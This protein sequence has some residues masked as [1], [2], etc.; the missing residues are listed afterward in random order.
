[1]LNFLRCSCALFVLLGTGSVHSF[2]SRGHAIICQIAYD[3][4]TPKTQAKVDALV[5]LSP[6]QTFSTGCSWPDKV[7]DQTAFKH[8]KP[9][10]Y[11][12]VD[13]SA[14]S[15]NA[16]DCP[17]DGCVVSAIA[18]ME[19]RLV[20]APATDWQA[21]FFLG[22][23]IGDIH[24]PLHVSYGDDWGGNKV[25]VHLDNEKTNLHAVWDG[26]MFNSKEAYIRQQ[27]R[28][29]NKLT[30]EDVAL[31][32]NLDALVWANESY[33]VTQAIYQHLDAPI[34]LNRDELTDERDL[35]ELRIGL[36]ALRLAHVLET[37][38]GSS[39]SNP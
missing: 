29:M 37:L 25:K 39:T 26:R 13:R 34:A 5:S 16:D 9:W 4:L 7:R 17:R 6:N 35:L 3:Q 12:N 1:M 33:A 32:N 18:E 36:A 11:I 14:T 19:E 27:K 31:A 30:A 10:H 8:T 24:Q 21:L 38:F 15:V 22:H 2:E 23:F 20:K 28:L